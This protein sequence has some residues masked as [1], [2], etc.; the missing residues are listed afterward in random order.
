M[1]TGSQSTKQYAVKYIFEAN[2]IKDVRRYKL[3]SPSFELFSEFV[4][5]SFLKKYHAESF[6]ARYE[7]DEGDMIT[8]AS[9]IELSEAFHVTHRNSNCLKVYILL[10]K[11]NEEKAPFSSVPPVVGPP[12]SYSD[13]QRSNP[14]VTDDKMEDEDEVHDTSM[15]DKEIKE[16]LQEF[17]QD[18]KIQG[19]LPV[20]LQTAFDALCNGDTAQSIVDGVL[21][22]YKDIKNH[23][24]VQKIIPLLPKYLPKLE[25]YRRNIM[26]QHSYI[27]PII[28]TQLPELVNKLPSLVSIDSKN[29]LPIFQALGNFNSSNY[30]ATTSNKRSDSGTSEPFSYSSTSN[31]GSNTRIYD[32]LMDSK[33]PNPWRNASNSLLSTT[34]TTITT[35]ITTTTTTTTS[36]PGS[37]YRSAVHEHVECDGCGVNPIK[38]FRYKCSV[39]ENYDLCQTCEAKPIHDKTH[40]LIKYSTP[41]SPRIYNHQHHHHLHLHHHGHHHYRHRHHRHHHGHR[42]HHHHHHHGHHHHH[43]GHHHR[44][45]HR[46]HHHGHHHHGHHHGHHHHGHHHRHGP[47][48]GFSGRC[49]VGRIRYEAKIHRS[50]KTIPDRIEVHQQTVLVKEW[51]IINNGTVAWPKG[52]KLFYLQSKS[53]LAS[54]QKEFDVQ[55][56][57]PGQCITI[58]ATLTTSSECGRQTAFFRLIDNGKIRFGPQLWCDVIVIPSN[59]QP[60]VPPISN[61]PSIEQKMDI[62]NPSVNEQ[63]EG[64]VDATKRAEKK[65]ESQLT[66]LQAMGFY[67]VDRMIY[68]LEQNNGDTQSVCEALLQQNKH[69]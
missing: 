5:N 54:V 57:K 50:D 63:T 51:E 52:T 41:Q 12:P 25:S 33:I 22:R 17:I 44:H 13:S 67:D 58:S 23:K 26:N 34:T 49:G 27:L 38:G 56:A 35:T 30:Y 1:N 37:S 66:K 9:D 3:N 59:T 28:K 43:H 18:P 4:R 45:H 42:H 40:P 7:D 36:L 16:L 15:S 32:P 31:K 60:S 46:H 24:T 14:T 65:W 61:A 21:A 11:R 47:H 29:I 19:V 10:K 68:Y 2:G 39:C 69:S 20:V 6:E 8:I 55:P 62:D 48:H 53:N 64:L